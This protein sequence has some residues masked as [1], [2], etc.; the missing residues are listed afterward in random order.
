MKTILRKEILSI[1]GL[2]GDPVHSLKYYASNY[3][4][5][6][7]I[8]KNQIEK[9]IKGSNLFPKEAK[10]CTKTEIG[11][12]YAEI[13]RRLK[14]NEFVVLTYDTDHGTI[15]EEKKFNN[16]EKASEYLIIKSNCAGGA[17]REFA[18]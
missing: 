18:H 13:L 7:G 3:P 1:L 10:K 17:I 2:G 4:N 9:D 15:C 12:K 16:L 8:I 5:L 11:T 6:M 14:G